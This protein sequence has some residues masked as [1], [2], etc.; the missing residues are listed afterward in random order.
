MTMEELLKLQEKIGTKAFRKKVVSGGPFIYNQDTKASEDNGDEVFNRANK[1][2]P[3]EVPMMRRAAP[4]MTSN[5]AGQKGKIKITRDPRF[6]DLSGKLNLNVWQGNYGFLSNRR[7]KEKEMLKKELKNEEDPVKKKKIK[8]VIQRMENQLREKERRNLENEVTRNHRREQMEAL[9]QGKKP[10]HFYKNEQKL[11]L[12]AAQF[13]QL[14]KE[15]RVDRYLERKEKR[16]RAKELR[17]HA[18]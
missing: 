7:K 15:N 17:G 6:D 11:L 1:N 14:K 13:E 2:R 4:R 5:D 16:L 9:R 18:H 12:K 3:R 8:S 10:K